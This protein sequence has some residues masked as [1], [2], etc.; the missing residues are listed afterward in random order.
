MK[1]I[2]LILAIAFSSASF[3]QGN[4][5]FNQVINSTITAAVE[6]TGTNIGTITVPTGKVWKI[7]TTGYSYFG[8]LT[9]YIEDNTS[10]TVFM[11]DFIVWNGNQ[12]DDNNRWFPLW[13]S[14]GTYTVNARSGT[15]HTSTFAISAIEFNVVP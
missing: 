12:N 1:N 3:G 13:L 4:L 8:G 2:L 7:E 6:T 9:R 10:A 14:E 11:G 15:A 5:Q